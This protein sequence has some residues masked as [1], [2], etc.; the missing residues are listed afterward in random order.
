MI[1]TSYLVHCRTSNLSKKSFSLCSRCSNFTFKLPVHL[2]LSNIRRSHNGTQSP[3]SSQ[4]SFNMLTYYRIIS[5]PI[6]FAQK[7]WN[8][9]FFSVSK[10]NTS[11]SPSLL[12]S[13]LVSYLGCTDK[14]QKLQSLLSFTKVSATLKRNFP[15]DMNDHTLIISASDWVLSFGSL[16]IIMYKILLGTLIWDLQ[17]VV[18]PQYYVFSLLQE[19]DPSITHNPGL[20]NNPV[21]TTA[22]NNPCID[23][24]LKYGNN[25]S[26]QPKGKVKTSSPGLTPVSTS[27]TNRSS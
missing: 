17:Q 11:F 16:F 21:S 6:L 15:S 14:K 9:N 7:K 22:L 5:E 1:I 20:R 10:R 13:M 18:S 19:P 26:P 2:R 3:I 27:C 8:S 12:F 25:Q 24:T 23:F 4:E